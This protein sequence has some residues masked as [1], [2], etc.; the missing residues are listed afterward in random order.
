VNDAEVDDGTVND[1][2]VNDTSANDVVRGGEHGDGGASLIW[3]GTDLHACAVTLSPDAFCWYVIDVILRQH[4]DVGGYEA[5]R[6]NCGQT[7]SA[8][9]HGPAGT[10]KR[11]SRTGPDRF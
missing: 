11:R 4:F 8:G 7:N 10:R 6:S 2:S 9:L 3:G 1:I 5:N